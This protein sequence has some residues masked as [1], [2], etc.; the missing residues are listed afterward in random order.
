MKGLII[1]VIIA[2]ITSIC[3]AAPQPPVVQKPGDWTLDVRYEN[4]QLITIDG[5]EKQRYWYIIV[6]LTNKNGKD[7]DFYPSAEIVTDTLQVLPAINGTSSLL[8]A[9][10]KARH[11]KYEFLQ[12][13]ENTD[14]KILQGQDNT[15]DM[16]I[17]WPEAID[18]NAHNVSIL[19]AGLSN[20]TVAVENPAVK[21]KDGNPVKVYLRKTLELD[22]TMGGDHQSMKFEGKKWVMR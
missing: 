15:V 17:C 21:D 22:Y 20:E 9:K 2:A 3:F 5:S 11:S 4:P 7:A 19:I 1:G 14:K 10:I 16:V 13:M 8:F 18:P 12:L 6:T